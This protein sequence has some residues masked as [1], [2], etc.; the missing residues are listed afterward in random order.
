MT[1]VA[2]RSQRATSRSQ[3]TYAGARGGDPHAP[4]TLGRPA[5][6]LRVERGRG[7]SVWGHTTSSSS[8]TRGWRGSHPLPGHG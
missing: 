4:P 8:L 1:S 7:C 3:A 5:Q 6:G 2:E